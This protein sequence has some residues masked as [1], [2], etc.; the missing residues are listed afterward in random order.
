MQEYGEWYSKSYHL[1]KQKYRAIYSIMNC[2]TEKCGWRVEQCE[3]C[4]NLDYS[5]NTCV[6]RNCTKCQHL[7]RE[8]WINNQ[9]SNM[10]NIPYFYT[11][12]TVP[13]ELNRLLYQN[14]KQGYDLLFKAASETLVEIEADEKYLGAELGFTMVLHI[15]SQ[16]LSLHPH[17]HA[18]IAGGGIRDGKWIACKKNIYSLSKCYQKFSEESF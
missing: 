7:A 4:N 1:S 2:R 5:Y 9:K 16:N 15:W 18:L 11:V 13:S 6:N 14:Q 12:F 17:L 3:N 8:K 10:L